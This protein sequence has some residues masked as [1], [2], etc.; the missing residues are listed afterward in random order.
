MAPIYLMLFN[1]IEMR[2]DIIGICTLFRRPLPLRKRNIGSWQIIFYLI[3]C[4][5]IFTNLFFS[6]FVT[7]DNN[8]SLKKLRLS[9]LTGRAHH[10]ESSLSYFFLL[11]HLVL[12]IIGLIN[13]LVSNVS[14]WVKTFL[15]RRDYNLKKNKWKVLLDRF[16]ISKH[17]KASEQK[18]KN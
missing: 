11:E 16:K 9:A 17:V 4:L 18:E 5:G 15:E 3:S 12:I 13:F 1:S 10:D 6:L 8:L 14:P 7:E 2:I